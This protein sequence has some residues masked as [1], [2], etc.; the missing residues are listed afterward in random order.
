MNAVG[1]VEEE[2]VG[3]VFLEKDVLDLVILEL[4]LEKSWCF[5]RGQMVAKDKS[6]QNIKQSEGDLQVWYSVDR[7]C[8]SRT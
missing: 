1:S 7:L 2:E 4:D 3:R 8:V 6:R 5:N